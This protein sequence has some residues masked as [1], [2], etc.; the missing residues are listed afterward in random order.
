MCRSCT[1][2]NGILW[3]VQRIWVVHIVWHFPLN[4]SWCPVEHWNMSNSVQ[5]NYNFGQSN[6]KFAQIRSHFSDDKLILWLFY[7]TADQQGCTHTENVLEQGRYSE[8]KMRFSRMERSSRNL[9]VENITGWLILRL[10]H[11]L[12]T[13]EVVWLPW[14]SVQERT[15]WYLLTPRRIGWLPFKDALQIIFQVKTSEGET[16]WQKEKHLASLYIQFLLWQC[17]INVIKVLLLLWC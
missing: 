5:I 15:L 12:R 17:L 4:F 13:L 6:N 8:K 16:Q 11:E 3:S 10:I 9:W 14:G 7:L 1:I 2:W